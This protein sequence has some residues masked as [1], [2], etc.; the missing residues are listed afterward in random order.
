[1]W[2]L[3]DRNEN[4]SLNLLGLALKAADE[5]PDKLSLGPVGPDATL[6]DGKTLA[7][8]KQA[9]GETGPNEG[10]TAPST[11]VSPSVDG[12]AASRAGGR[13]EALITVQSLLAI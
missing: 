2:N 13:M 6:P 12:G 5:L 4:A 8:G 7:D 1:M 3:H 11:W 9:A 10:R